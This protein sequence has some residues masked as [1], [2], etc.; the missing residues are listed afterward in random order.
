[1]SECQEEACEE[2]C[3]S[4]SSQTILA[5]GRCHAQQGPDSWF[6]HLYTQQGKSSFSL[7]SHKT[8][9]WPHVGHMSLGGPITG[10]LRSGLL[11]L[12]HTG[13]QSY[14]ITN[15]V[16]GKSKILRKDG[17]FP[18][19]HRAEAMERDRQKCLTPQED[20]PA[21]KLTVP[22]THNWVR[23]QNKQGCI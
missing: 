7:Q 11:W 14:P 22:R 20:F 16:T 10:G 3:F 15:R 12:A 13:L 21:D 19:D 1:M 2:A 17:L 18:S 9:L 8:G 4:T 6:L 23:E 5:G